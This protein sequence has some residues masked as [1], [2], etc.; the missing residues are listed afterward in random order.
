M[1]DNSRG[2][3]FII[4]ACAF[5]A[6]TTALAKQVS[7][8]VEDA[9]HPLQVTFG[10][11]LFGFLTLVPFML[12]R[13][14]GFAGTRW[15]HHGA[16]VLFGWGGVSCM[17]T[18]VTLMPLADAT[19]ITFLN[20]FFTMVL[21][22]LFLSERVGKWRWGAA[23]IAFSGVLVLTQPGSS[24]FQPAALIALAGAAAMGTEVLF[25]KLLTM[26]EPHP[27]IL[28]INNM[29]GAV[30]S[31]A[32]ALLVWQ[33]PSTDQWIALAAIGSLMV[34][35][36]ALFLRGMTLGEAAFVAPFLFLTLPF[37]ALYGG[38]FFGEIPAL[39]TVAGAGLILAGAGILGWRERR[40]GRR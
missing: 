32:A 26:R 40:A 39:T 38:L 35:A 24:A 19:A 18:A 15:T 28:L 10:R 34:T 5:I 9:L 27:R 6:A 14:P 23:A 17:F 3:L 8:P 36:Q 11:F 2:A 13:R 21:A 4:L 16:R 31:G 37:A 30:I 25:I 1:T 33:T 12:Y 7:G 20:P 22:I 29:A